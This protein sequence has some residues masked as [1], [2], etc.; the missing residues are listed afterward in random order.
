VDIQVV[1][2]VR[3]VAGGTSKQAKNYAKKM[4][5]TVDKEIGDFIKAGG[6]VE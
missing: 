4:N 3:Q 1:V 2:L 6:I 5:Q